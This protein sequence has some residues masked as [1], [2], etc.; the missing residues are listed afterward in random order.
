MSAGGSIPRS[1]HVNQT[2]AVAKGPRAPSF[3]KTVRLKASSKNRG[4]S[5]V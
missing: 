1:G 3:S 2:L 4:K 5:I